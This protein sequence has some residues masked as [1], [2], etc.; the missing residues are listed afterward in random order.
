MPCCW[1]RTCCGRGGRTACEP[2]WRCGAS[3]TLSVRGVKEAGQFPGTSD[4]VMVACRLH[5]LK[6]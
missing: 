5:I 2:R 6:L 4:V 3:R 1:R